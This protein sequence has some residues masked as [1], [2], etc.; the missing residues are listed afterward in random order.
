MSLSM[1]MAP[2][3]T[4]HYAMGG[5]LVDPETQMTTVDGLFAAGEC[6]A[7]LHGANRLGGNSL[8]DLIVFGKRAGESAARYAAEHGDVHPDMAAVERSK[9]EA[10]KLKEQ[11]VDSKFETEGEYAIGCKQPYL[12]RIAMLT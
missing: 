8:S 5:I 7:G 2:A 3:P 1:V 4:V 9:L 12:P 6:A 10:E 11:L